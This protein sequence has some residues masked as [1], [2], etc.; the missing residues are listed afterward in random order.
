MKKTHFYR[1]KATINLILVVLT[2]LV[3]FTSCE[4]IT[5][6]D[7][8]EESIPASLEPLVKKQIVINELAGWNAYLLEDEDGDYSDWVE[9]HNISP[10]PVNLK[11]WY[12]SDERTFLNKWMFSASYI[13][14]PGDNLVIYLSG[15]D[16]RTGRNS[17]QYHT[18][19]VIDNNRETLFLTSSD[20][21]I[22]DTLESHAPTAGFSIGRSSDGISNWQFF[23][24]PTPG[25]TNTLNIPLP[26]LSYS[27]GFYQTAQSLLISAENIPEGY[28]LRYTINDGVMIDDQDQAL[29]RY[30]WEYPSNNTGI[31][32]SENILIEKTSVIKARLFKGI[33]AGPE[34][35]Y[36]YFI[37]E[38]IDIPIISLT[39]DP[40][41]LWSAEQGI[42]VTG[43][44]P[45]NPNY[46]QD[47]WEI[48]ARFTYFTDSSKQSPDIDIPVEL[49]IF[50]SA[51]RAFPNKS[52]A[53]YSRSRE[54]PNL[55]FTNNSDTVYSLLLRT[56][57]SDF[58]RAVMRDIITSELVRP[59]G[60]DAQDYQQ[61]LLFINGQF[62]GISNIREKINEEMI[63][64]NY[65]INPDELDLIF[66]TFNIDP[67]NGTTDAYSEMYNYITSTNLYL[68][69]YYQM[70]ENYIDINAFIDY[71]IVETFINNGDWPSNNVKAWKSWESNSL[72]R[73]I[74]YD[75]DASYDTEEFWSK[76]NPYEGKVIGRPD[77]D[78]INRLLEISTS[79]QIVK[80]FTGL[81][82][83]QKFKELFIQRYEELIG[84][85]DGK[86]VN[87]EAFLG[88]KRI[89]SV[90]NSIAGNIEPYIPRQL[91]RWLPEYPSYMRTKTVGS[92]DNTINRWYHNVS[93]L[94]D[95]AEQRPIYVAQ[96]LYEM[97]KTYVPTGKN[98][99]ENGSFNDQVRN[100]NVRW[101][102]DVS[103][104]TVVII[105]DNNNVGE[106]HIAKAYQHSEASEAS[107]I[108]AFVYDG[109]DLQN[110]STY[111]LSFNTKIASE[112][113]LPNSIVAYLFKKSPDY[114]RYAQLE[115]VPTQ[116]WQTVKKVFTLNTV[117]DP[118]ARLQFRMGN[119]PPGTTIYI[120]DI[121]LTELE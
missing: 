20:R 36:T 82:N 58:T 63:E 64:D 116:E 114:T 81:M 39:I 32:Y 94:R 100:W 56:G 25:E 91:T 76:T 77:F 106:I 99:I 104:Q 92:D 60:I 121:S 11:G 47:D 101:S 46:L 103:T 111:E 29:N 13:L 66:G 105:D 59:I 16:R 53:I 24:N 110:N 72:W 73:W 102:D 98:I 112:L 40:A 41:N 10:E 15:K 87:P 12:L 108:V 7:S 37:N 34:V 68:D 21:I 79:S 61:S 14:N 109:I 52:L 117:S 3:I 96:F 26:I 5:Q 71:I 90:I 115:I 86:I 67:R 42:Y 49:R 8:I 50:G 89:I 22:Q 51:T 33:S 6:K 17:S 57:A 69:K 83:N 43:D 4:T 74:I 44:D 65:Q 78:S 88:S 80:I 38:N 55:F 2:L 85:E 97:N 95:F 35:I 119:L 31:Q 70:V 107:D 118:E 120:D 113:F 75:T 18:N 54:L 45:D 27:S 93:V 23:S 48:P 30:E 19:F 1:K 62:W 9:L 28:E 84:A